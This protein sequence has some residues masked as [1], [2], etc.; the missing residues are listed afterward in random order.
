MTLTETEF[1]TMAIT[2]EDIQ[3]N[4][5]SDELDEHFRGPVKLEC[6]MDEHEEEES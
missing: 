2:F 5:E 3:F 6:L 1:K 4:E